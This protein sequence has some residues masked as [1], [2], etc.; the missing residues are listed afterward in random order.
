MRKAA[1]ALIATIAMIIGL[2]AVAPLPANA[3]NGRCMADSCNGKDPVGKCEDGITVASKAV[4]DGMLEL[5]Y[6]ASCK[7]NWGRYTPYWNNAYSNVL[8]NRNAMPIVSVWNPGKTSYGSANM[9]TNPL[10]FDTSWSKMTDGTK[11][12]CTGVRILYSGS[13]SKNK[14][15]PA[16]W[17]DSIWQ[18]GPCY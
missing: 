7:S 1:A 15:N 14:Q 9:N 5:W 18:W 12:A 2:L 3:A 4:Q 16:G 8:S 6:S 13:N 11:E 10:Q 17:E